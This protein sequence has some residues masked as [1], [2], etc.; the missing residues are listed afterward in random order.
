MAASDLKFALAHIVK[1][2]ERDTQQSI[3]VTYGSSGNMA[4]QLLQGLPAD[5]F[6]SAD[7]AL[8]AQLAHAGLTR[9]MGKSDA[10]GAD[11]GVLYAQGR[12][13]VVVPAS[14]A[15]PLD[16]EITALRQSW[17]LKAKFA[18]ANPEHAPYGRAA[19]QVLQAL[20]L[21][22]AVQPHL[23]LGENIAQTTQ[24]VATGAATMGITALSLVQAP[25]LA[26]QMRHLP[27]PAHLHAPLHQ[28]MV[29]LKVA[30][31]QAV[32]F[33]DY[34]QQP[35]ARAALLKYGFEAPP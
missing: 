4:R 24:F 11:L 10:V 14:S 8:V 31:P 18:I 2:Y 17:P 3:E 27:L 25:E 7:E 28:R 29:L 5:L 13:A 33:Y 9:R 6:M 30:S 32:A 15:L 22:S 16:A 19:Q 12:L 21:W 35:Q 23:V 20:G 1:K 34:L 26:G